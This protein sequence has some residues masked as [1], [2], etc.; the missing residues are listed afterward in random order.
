[1]LYRVA[2]QLGWQ[3]QQHGCAKR[4]GQRV[5]DVPC[6]TEW[7]GRKAC[8]IRS[9]R[10]VPA[11]STCRTLRLRPG[12]RRAQGAAR[13]TAGHIPYRHIGKRGTVDEPVERRLMARP[14]AGAPPRPS[15]MPDACSMAAR[16]RLR[17]RCLLGVHGIS[18]RLMDQWNY[19]HGKL[20]KN[21]E[22]YRNLFFHGICIL[23][24]IGFIV[25]S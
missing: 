12:A 23:K 24:T 6:Y 22:T 4:I 25:F 18:F 5:I 2:D 9:T 14:Q 13:T 3:H 10:I 21:D 8:S 11:T 15:G 19:R 20:S 16:G 7:R 1:M 17:C